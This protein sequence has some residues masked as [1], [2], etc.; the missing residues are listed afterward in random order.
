MVNLSETFD[1]RHIEFDIPNAI[2]KSIKMGANVVGDLLGPG[3]VD[4][5][6]LM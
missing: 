3:L 4:T 2:P 5:A 6:N 1:S